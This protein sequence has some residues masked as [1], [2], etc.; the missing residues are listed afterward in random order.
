MQQMYSCPNCGAQIAFG[1]RFCGNCGTAVSW[2][3]QQP[4]RSPRGRGVQQQVTRDQLTPERG[5]L[6]ISPWA[7]LVGGAFIGAVLGGWLGP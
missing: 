2:P 3:E 1:V 4:G 6:S 7:K 5:K